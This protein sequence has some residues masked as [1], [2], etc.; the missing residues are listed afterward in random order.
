MQPDVLMEPFSTTFLYPR[1]LGY[2]DIGHAIARLA[3]AY[4]MKIIASRRR[5]VADE[6]CETVYDSSKESLARIFQE[7]DYIV[8]ALP[9][10]PET[11]AVLD[12]ELL[13]DSS[14]EDALIM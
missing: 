12:A 14:R 7:S 8:S 3:S 11:N 6:L 2:G 1:L 5:P 9:L 13:G 4:G 10:T